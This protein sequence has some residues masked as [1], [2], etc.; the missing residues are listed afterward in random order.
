MP[1]TSY[2]TVLRM[3]NVRPLRGQLRTARADGDIEL[4]PGGRRGT[5]RNGSLVEGPVA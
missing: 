1:R 5:W 4:L 3:R 2:Q